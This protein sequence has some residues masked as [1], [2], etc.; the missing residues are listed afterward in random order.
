MRCLEMRRPV[1]LDIIL[2]GRYYRQLRYTK[3]GFPMLVDGEVLETYEAKDIKDF[4]EEQLPSL[5]GR[6]Y[7]IEFAKQRV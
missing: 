7:K 5:V 4:V 1:L 6:N 2:E 3:R